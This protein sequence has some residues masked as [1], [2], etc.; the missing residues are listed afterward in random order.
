[1]PGSRPP[2]R[3]LSRNRDVMLLP[4]SNAYSNII[5]Q[6]SYKATSRQFR[7][8]SDLVFEQARLGN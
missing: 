1:M 2:V 6:N 8:T 3:R 5:P 4:V 7:L